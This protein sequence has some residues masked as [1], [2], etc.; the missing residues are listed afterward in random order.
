MKTSNIIIVVLVVMIIA[1]SYMLIN[2]DTFANNAAKKYHYDPGDSFITNVTNSSALIKSDII[3]EVNDENTYKF[4]SDNEFKVRDIIINI[5]RKKTLE[6]A[7]QED[8][9]DNL[10]IEI[11]EA[12][13]SNFLFLNI[14]DVYFN[15][16]VIQ[17]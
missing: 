3:I 17:Q 8:C 5:L 7:I 9:Q 14:E 16:F 6:E 2:F 12:L 4:F 13:K 10:K 1:L 11:V 15:E